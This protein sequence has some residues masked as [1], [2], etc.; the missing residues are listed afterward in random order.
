[1][2]TERIRVGNVAQLYTRPSSSRARRNLARQPLQAKVPAS[3]VQEP[4][5]NY[6]KRAVIECIPK[7]PV[8]PHRC[9]SP[10]SPTPGPH[11]GL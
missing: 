4:V 2:A 1:M 11:R 3:P 9:E 5:V 7:A 6:N 8:Q 10:N